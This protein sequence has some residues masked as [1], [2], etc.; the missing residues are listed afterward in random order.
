VPALDT[1]FQ[2]QSHFTS[3]FKR[4]TGKTPGQWRNDVADEPEAALT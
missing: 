4:L 3:V 1:G 2:T